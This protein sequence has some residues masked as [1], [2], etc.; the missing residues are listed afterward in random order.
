MRISDLIATFGTKSK[1][2]EIILLAENAKPVVRQGFYKDELT[3][4]I[5]FCKQHNLTIVI[6]KFKI[7]L[8]KQ[9][10]HDGGIRV[11]EN[12]PRPGMYF[13]YIS[14]D[15]LLAYQ[16]SYAELTLNHQALGELLGYPSCCIQYFIVNFNPQK[17]NL[18]LPATN[19]WTNLSKRE[20]DFVLL[21]HFPCQSNCHKSIQLAQQYYQVITKNDPFYA[22]MLL[23]N[24]Q[25][26]N[27]KP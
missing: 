26:K 5:Q 24:L 10:F 8:S 25:I 19:P 9:G 18:S 6:S 20:S 1:S 17:T 2:Q 3:L 27:L 11:P 16:A 23:K 12:D 22:S 7:L 15:E 14:K 13:V 4:I 21:S